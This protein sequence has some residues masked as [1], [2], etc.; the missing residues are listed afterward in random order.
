LKVYPS[1]LDSATAST[2][3][4]SGPIVWNR[5]HVFYSSN[6]KP[7]A[8]EHSDRGLCSGTRGP[9]AMP[10]GS[11]NSNMKRGNSLVLCR[12]RGCC[13][14]LHRS[15]RRSLKPVGFD[16]LSSCAS[17]YCLGAGEVG[18]VDHCDVGDSPSVRR[19]L[20]L[21]RHA[22]LPD[23]LGLEP[24]TNLNSPRTRADFPSLPSNRE[25]SVDPLKYRWQEVT[26]T[27]RWRVKLE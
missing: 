7:V 6:S 21:L 19:C 26:R 10:T 15:V 27:H 24:C 12:L 17:G 22:E 8:G 1:W 18:Y 2:A 11:S 23:R 14:S 13:R 16:V 25:N 5:C 9:S 20:G 4:S 3:R